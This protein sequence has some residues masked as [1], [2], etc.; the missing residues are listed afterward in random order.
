[1]NCGNWLKCPA[2]L[3]MHHL[4]RW[5]TFLGVSASHPF[6]FGIVGLYVLAWI[7]INPRSFDWQ[8]FATVATWIMT[9]FIQ[10]AE[11]RDTQAIHAKLDELLRA[12]G[13]ARTDLAT[14]DRR[15][16]EDIERHRLKS[17]KKAAEPLSSNS[18]SD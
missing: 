8:S 1:M 3:L 14:M 4:R 16:P 9:L 5:L 17:H 13:N 15:E 11:H 12:E 6:A 18:N 10:R 2:F 7:V